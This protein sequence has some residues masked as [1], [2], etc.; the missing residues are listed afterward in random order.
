MNNR[1][2]A[3]KLLLDGFGKGDIDFVKSVVVKDYI[4]HDPTAPDGLDGLL[5]FM[6]EIGKAPPEQ[7]PIIRRVRTITDG[8][9]VAMHSDYFWG[10]KVAAFDV[11]RLRD[12]KVMEHWSAA[13]PQPEH[14][15]SGHTMLDGPTEIE[16][17]ELTQ[18][19]KALIKNFFEQVIIGGNFAAMPEFFDGDKYIQHSPMIADGVSGLQKGFA[20]AA[21][22]GAE[23]RYNEV[24]YMLGEGN[25]VLTMG[26]GTIGGKHSV[27]F[28]LFRIAKGKIAEHWDVVQEIPAESKNLNGML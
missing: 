16:D 6:G 1:Q 25:M 21:A 9:M 19:N 23:I 18:Q 12:G 4:Q 24:K 2:I 15:A 28:D 3:E 17:A 10:G 7:R 27:F 11:F 14:T 22:A 20:A 8:N 5:L 26:R 13:Q